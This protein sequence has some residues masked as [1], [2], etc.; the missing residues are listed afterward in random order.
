[1]AGIDIAAGFSAQLTQI[2][3]AL[4]KA[5]PPTQNIY[6]RGGVLAGG[7]GVQSAGLGG[8]TGGNLWF[9]RRISI[10]PSPLTSSVSLGSGFFIL[11][12]VHTG[13]AGAATLAVPIDVAPTLPNTVTYGSGEFVIR[14]PDHLIVAWISGTGTV[15]LD[16]DVV[17]QPIEG[18][19]ELVA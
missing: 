14:H 15:S 18:E 1:M 9:V 12:G 5:Q 3:K 7:A 19:E 16:I 8:P 2:Q 10:M 13:A 4:A 6:S 11:K 17:E